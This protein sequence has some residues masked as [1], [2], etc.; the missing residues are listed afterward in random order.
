VKSTQALITPHLL[1]VA[2]LATAAEDGADIGDS[3][4]AAVSHAIGDFDCCFRADAIKGEF[5][6]VLTQL[7][8]H[9]AGARPVYAALLLQA[10]EIAAHITQQ[11]PAMPPP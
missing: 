3:V 5:V 7:G 11:R 10:A 9:A 4:E 6:D 8:Q 1:T 2:E